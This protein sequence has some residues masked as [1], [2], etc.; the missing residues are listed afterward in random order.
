MLRKLN[1]IFQNYMREK[2]LKLGRY[3]YDKKEIKEEIKVG[4]FIE[5]NNI[6]EKEYYNIKT[7][8]GLCRLWTQIRT[9]HTSKI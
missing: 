3:L 7:L 9:F 6:N 5:N 8:F 4:N 1:R 2:R